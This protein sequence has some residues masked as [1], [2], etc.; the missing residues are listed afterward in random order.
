MLYI[1]DDL[2]AHYENTYV[3]NTFYV[4]A[5]S[6]ICCIPPREHGASIER[7]GAQCETSRTPLKLLR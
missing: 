6:R 2:E 7:S 5:L 1:V 4:Y 3:P